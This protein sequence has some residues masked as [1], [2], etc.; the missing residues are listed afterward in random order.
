LRGF[1]WR[2]LDEIAAMTERLD[3]PALLQIIAELRS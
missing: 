3:P 1:A 2:T